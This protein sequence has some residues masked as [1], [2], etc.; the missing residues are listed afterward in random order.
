MPPTLKEIDLKKIKDCNHPD[1]VI[2]NFYLT[3]YKMADQK[4]YWY[5]GQF[6]LSWFGLNFCGIYLSGVKLE[7]SNI[8]EIYEIVESVSVDLDVDDSFMYPG[9]PVCSKK[10][11]VVEAVDA[12]DLVIES[13]GSTFKHFSQTPETPFG[14]IKFGEGEKKIK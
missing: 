7:D 8:K 5:A 13:D 14:N 3:K 4:D 12:D 10:A 11:G 9:M 1:I 2:G 6:E